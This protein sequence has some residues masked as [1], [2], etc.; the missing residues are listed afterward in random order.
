MKINILV[1]LFISNICISQ[2]SFI[3]EELKTS[4]SD[5]QSLFLTQQSAER[6]QKHLYNLTQEPHITTSKNNEKVRDYIVD[7]MK[8]TGL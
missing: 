3:K 8:K 6:Y 1:F 4:E 5:I 7:V 2:D